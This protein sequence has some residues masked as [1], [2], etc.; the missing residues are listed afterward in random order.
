MSMSDP[1]GDMLTR[2]R[3]AL[4]VKHASVKCLGSKF[5]ASI[6]EVMRVE[7]YIRGFQVGEDGRSIKVALKY[8]AGKP[9]IEE[10]KQVSRPGLR[11]YAGSTEIKTVMN[12]LGIAIMSTS[13]GVIT[14]HEAR[15]LGVGGE[16]ICQLA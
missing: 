10:I 3:N 4:A 12:G 8:Y 2:I 9:V 15:K 7:G 6:L 11:R 16:I 13:K 1:V 14:D 5:N